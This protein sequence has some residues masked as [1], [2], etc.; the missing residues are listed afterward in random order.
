MEGA[1][2]ADNR[3]RFV[4]LW[5]FSNQFTRRNDCGYRE[6]GPRQK[7]VISVYPNSKSAKNKRQGRYRQTC[8]EQGC[9]CYEALP[10]LKQEEKPGSWWKHVGIICGLDAA[11]G[12][13]WPPLVYQKWVC[14]TLPKAVRILSAKLRRLPKIFASP[15]MPGRMSP[16]ASPRGIRVV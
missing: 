13:P 1:A 14:I 11:S 2:A 3:C 5:K 4:V 10:F 12:G 9:G 16:A 8:H 15:L 6:E 7:E